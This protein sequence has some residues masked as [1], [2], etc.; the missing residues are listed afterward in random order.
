MTMPSSNC[1]IAATNIPVKPQRKGGI[2]CMTL[3]RGL[4]SNPGIETIPAA[5][6]QAGVSVRPAADGIGAPGQSKAQHLQLSLLNS[7]SLLWQRPTTRDQLYDLISFVR[8]SKINVACI[9]EMSFA[10]GER[11]SSVFIEEYM[12]ILA[13]STGIR[14]DPMCR[15][16]FQNGGSTLQSEVKGH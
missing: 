15:V 7:R 16:A 10:G 6:A 5:V 2:R 11:V 13:E 14:L 1:G 12:F 8:K 9:S 4:R 3:S